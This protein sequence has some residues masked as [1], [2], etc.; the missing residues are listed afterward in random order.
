MIS[1]LTITA[2]PDRAFLLVKE[3]QHQPTGAS[4]MASWSYDGSNILAILK[5]RLM[6]TA[7]VHA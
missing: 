3:Q 4:M 6:H 7:R 5:D 1:E 2:A